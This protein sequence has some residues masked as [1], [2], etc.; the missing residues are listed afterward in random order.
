VLSSRP[1]GQC[2]SSLGSF[3]EWM[4]NST[5]GPPTICCN[6]IFETLTTSRFGVIRPW[7]LLSSFGHF[8]SPAHSGGKW[9]SEHALTDNQ[10]RDAHMFFTPTRASDRTPSTPNWV[11]TRSDRRTDRSVRLRLR[12]TVYQTSQTDR[13]DRL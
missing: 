8:S 7:K 4:Y 12:P 13:S 9:E 10:S 2:E 11:F 5:E 3:N 1:Q 6:T